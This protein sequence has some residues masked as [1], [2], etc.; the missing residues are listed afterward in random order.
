[1]PMTA[2]SAE[3]RD[4]FETAVAMARAVVIEG[5]PPAHIA[6]FWGITEP[7]LAATLIQ[8]LGLLMFEVAKATNAWPDLEAMADG[9][10]PGD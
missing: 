5:T 6:E 2:T 3:K 4:A 9:L 1:M 7:R 10:R 8:H